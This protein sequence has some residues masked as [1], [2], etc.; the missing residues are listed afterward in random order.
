MY[1]FLNE[2]SLEEHT[3]WGVSLRAFLLAAQELRKAGAMLFRDSEAFQKYEFITHFNALGLP[4]DV[5]PLIRAMVFGERYYECWRPNRQSERNEVFSCDQPACHLQDESLAEAAERKLRDSRSE[6]AVVSAA[7]SA[8]GSE[9][10]LAIRRTC[11]SG[12]AELPNVIGPRVGEWIASQRGFYD[13]ASR[14]APRDFQTVLQREPER[15]KA[16]GKVERRSGRRIFEEC[17]TGHLFYVDDGHYGAAAHLEV[18]SAHGDHLGTADIDAGRVDETAR[19]K[20]R[21]LRL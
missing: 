1:A 12:S 21:Y 11:S 15:F 4:S 8:F 5:R 3:D 19:V 9:R 10:A 16:S 18:F 6:I 17:G 7:G 13:R 2:R 20:G 14:S